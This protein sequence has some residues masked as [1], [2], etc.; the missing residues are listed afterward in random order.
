VKRLAVVAAAVAAIVILA[1]IGRPQDVAEKSPAAVVQTSTALEASGEP[2]PGP[3]TTEPSPSSEDGEADDGIAQTGPLG[4]EPARWDTQSTAAAEQAAVRV[5]GVFA[6]PDLAYDQWWPP[7]RALLSPS[8]VN[9][10]ESVDPARI[11]VRAVTGTP[12]VIDKR[13]ALMT[14]V[15]VPT[16]AGVYVVTLLRLDGAAPW[17]AERLHPP[18]SK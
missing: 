14:Q 10:Y 3:T 18:E 1:W 15:E 5:M 13:S 8:A 12:R 11:P 6:H 2:R 9:A 4:P 7:L 17:L 16:D